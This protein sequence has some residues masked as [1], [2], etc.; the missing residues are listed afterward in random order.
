MDL[1]AAVGSYSADAVEQLLGWAHDMPSAVAPLDPIQ[2]PQY[3][4]TQPQ[5]DV[6]IYNQLLEVRA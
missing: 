2:Y 5:A 4:L 6:T 1:A 3:Q